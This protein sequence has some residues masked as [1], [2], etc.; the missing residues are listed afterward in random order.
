MQIR[1]QPKPGDRIFRPRRIKQ[2]RLR[3]V[4]GVP[5]VFSA[6]YGNVGSSIYYALGIVALVALGATPV[7][8]GI[9][10][11]LFIFTALTYAEGTAMFPEAGGS[12]SFARHAFDD[13]AGF[14]AGWAL[15]LSYIVTISISAFTIPPYLGFFWEP[16]K[17]SP[18]VGTIASIAIVVFLMVINVIGIKE[19]SFVNISAAVL[20]L[21]TQVSLVVIG[22]ILLFDPT[23]LI[24]RIFDNWPAPENLIIGIALAA[25]AYTGIETMSQMAEETRQPEKRVPRAL[26]MMIVAVLT[27]FAGIS[28]VS[29]SAMSPQELASEWS[30]D[31]VAGI[32]ANL[33]LPLLREVLKPLIAILAG[34]ILLI[35]TNAGL[36]G[37]SRLAFS[38]GNHKLIPPALSRIHPRFKTPYIAIVLFSI[39]AIL[40]LVP[41]FFAADVFKNLGA[42]YAVGSLLAFMFAHASIISLRLKRPDLPRPF[43]LGWNIR[44]K[45]RELPLTAILG[46]SVL[47]LIWVIILISQPY[48]RWVGLAWMIG[49][50]VIYYFYRRK[51]GLPLSYTPKKEREINQKMY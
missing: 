2:F 46:I 4:L 28:L 12:A 13:L 42:L 48:S 37:I 33:P 40:I 43:K 38:L 34:T 44:F 14:A 15:M 21:A 32:A 35:A 31:P 50:L 29:L 26:V 1:W 9:A 16:F 8:L 3:R 10:G 47:A 17:T 49:G 30:R 39:V 27:I 51:E 7:A 6:G 25:I 24:H 45:G 41:G 22:F 19:T 11:I 5:A 23:L 36:I 18:V 20:D